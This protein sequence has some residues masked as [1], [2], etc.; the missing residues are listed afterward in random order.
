LEIPEI[1]I[2]DVHI[3]YTYVPDYSHSNI[4][5][6][7]C[8]YYHRD[9]KNTGNRNLIIED[10]NG[11]ISNCP[12]PSFYPLN[13]QPDQL[14]IVEEAAPIQQESKPLPEGKPPQ[15]KIPK[16]KKKEET[17][18]PCPPKNA[19]YREGDFKNELRL[20]RLVRYERD[21]SDGSCN[22][23]WEK[24]PFIDQYI[25]TPSTIVLNLVKPLVKQVIKK[26]T[27]RKSKNENEE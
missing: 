14:T 19:P 2:P 7:G 16:D 8:T 26:L 10:P 20:E 13:Y 18:Q 22:A 25:P 27:S 1:H 9:T 15:A 5:V 23:V 12:Y 3:P 21:I 11:V 4:Q 24:V 17:Y 6:I